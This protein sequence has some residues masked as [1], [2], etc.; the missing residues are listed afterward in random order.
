MT[1]TNR[2]MTAQTRYT[3]DA[4][5]D[6]SAAFAAQIDS[7][8]AYL[9]RAARMKLRDFSE[10]EDVVQDTLLAAWNGRAGFR[11]QS[12]LRTWLVGILNHKVVD[13]IRER[14]R[15]PAMSYEDAAG[16]LEDSDAIDALGAATVDDAAITYERRKLCADVMD[17]LEAYS[18]KAAKIFVMREI[19]GED[20]RAICRR[21]SVSSANCYVLLHRARH[22]LNQRFE[23]YAVAG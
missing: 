11:G 7:H 14:Q 13:L 6:S 21:L 2:S 9:L 18:P 23:A 1:A 19:E 3:H 16:G 10:A 15:R 17:E 8:R 12:A 5:A 4:V 22:F 20:T